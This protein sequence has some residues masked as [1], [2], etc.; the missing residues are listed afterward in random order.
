MLFETHFFVTLQLWNVL[1]AIMVSHSITSKGSCSDR[2]SPGI[3][4]I[5]IDRGGKGEG[6]VKKFK[7]DPEALVLL[8]HGYV[9]FLLS[10]VALS[11]STRVLLSERENA[12]L[13]VTC[14]SRVF[15]LE[16]V[17]HHGFEIQGE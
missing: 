3:R 7:T 2:A 16:S 11:N 10:S 13:N 12:G 14:A 6:P 9:H 1:F 4:S 15:L 17:V 5:R 8:L